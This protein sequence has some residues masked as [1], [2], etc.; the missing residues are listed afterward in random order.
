M[1]SVSR[2][3][4]SAAGLIPL[5]LLSIDKLLLRAQCKENSR[6]CILGKVVLLALLVFLQQQQSNNS[7]TVK[8]QLLFGRILVS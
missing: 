1:A 7:N 4:G 8:I 5:L 3:L 2:F 6:K